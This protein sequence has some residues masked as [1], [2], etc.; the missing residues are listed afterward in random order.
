MHTDKNKHT[1]HKISFEHKRTSEFSEGQWWYFKCHVY[2]LCRFSL[3]YHFCSK[4]R[5]ISAICAVYTKTKSARTGRNTSWKPQARWLVHTRP[6]GFNYLST[7]ISSS[8]WVLQPVWGHKGHF[9]PAPRGRRFMG[10][11]KTTRCPWK[12]YCSPRWSRFCARGGG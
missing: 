10:E 5:F 8:P 3:P 4:R 9:L 11:E 1:S 7:T 12:S 6:S 2:I